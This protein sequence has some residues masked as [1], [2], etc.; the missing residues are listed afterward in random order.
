MKRLERY[1]GFYEQMEGV[2]RQAGGE[3]CGYLPRPWAES[4]DQSISPEEA[5]RFGT[6][7]PI[8]LGRRNGIRPGPHRNHNKNDD[9]TN[10]V[11]T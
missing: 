4:V 3:S 6:G 1:F 10:D 2:P 7:G 11:T 8:Q 5:D 9:N